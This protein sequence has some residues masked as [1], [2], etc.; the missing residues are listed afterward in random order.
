MILDEFVYAWKRLGK[1]QHKQSQELEKIYVARFFV[2]TVNYEVGVLVFC[3][4][5]NLHYMGINENP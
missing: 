5:N 2:V 1:P 3:V 4:W